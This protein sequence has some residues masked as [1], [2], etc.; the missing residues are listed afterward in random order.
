MCNFGARSGVGIYPGTVVSAH[1]H[2]HA[3]SSQCVLSLRSLGNFHTNLRLVSVS[4]HHIL[5]GKKK[6]RRAHR[7]ERSGWAFTAVHSRRVQELFS[8]L[9]VLIQRWAFTPGGCLPRVGVHPGWVFT[10]YFTAIVSTLRNLPI[11]TPLHCRS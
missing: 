7:K 3:Q 1:P 5:C 8:K 9:G 2:H 6:C 10:P 4:L 11:N